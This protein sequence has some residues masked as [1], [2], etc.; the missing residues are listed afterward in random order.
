VNNWLSYDPEFFG[1]KRIRGGVLIQRV[2][3][4]PEG[5]KRRDALDGLSE[6]PALIIRQWFP[7]AAIRLPVAKPL[8]QNRITG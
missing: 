4:R 8:L 7:V 1:R 2:K 3:R 6:P 5:K